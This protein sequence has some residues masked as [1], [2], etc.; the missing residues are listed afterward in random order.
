MGRIRE[1]E[2]E[3]GSTQSKTGESFKAFQR[4][5]RRVKELQFQ[6][7]EDRKNQDRMSDLANKLQQ[8]IKTYKTQIE[9]AEELLLL[10]WQNTAR[11]NKSWRKLKREPSWLV[12]NWKPSILEQ[13]QFKWKR[14]ILICQQ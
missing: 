13:Q 1:L 11:P 2:M 4:A 8:K 10:T 12:P 7:E 9:E 5:E 3:L 6:Q 14:Q